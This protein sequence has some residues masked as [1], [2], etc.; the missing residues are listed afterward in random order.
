MVITYKIQ[1][2]SR[3]KSIGIKVEAY[4]GN[5]TVFAPK[6]TPFLRIEAVVKGREAWIIE[7]VNAI[8]AKNSILPKI[9]SGVSLYIAGKYYLLNL[10]DVRRSSIKGKVITL[11]RENAK[12]SLVELTKR[13][14]LPYIMQKTNRFASACGFKYESVSLNKA[15]RKWGSCTSTGKITYTVALAFLPEEIC[16]YVVLHELCHTKEMNHQKGFYTLLS[17]FMPDYKSR[18]KYLK[19]YSSYLSY[20]Y[21]D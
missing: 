7:K 4:T 5:V 18:Q 3:R 8:K 2:S 11:S 16:D 13:M 17:K 15:K 21:E 20:F 1:R 9:E 19:I 14:F 6:N 10:S 12:G